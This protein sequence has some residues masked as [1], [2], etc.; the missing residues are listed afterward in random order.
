M[1]EEDGGRQVW[2][3][4]TYEWTRSKGCRGTATAGCLSVPADRQSVPADHLSIPAGRPGCAGHGDAG[5][6]EN[7]VHVAWRI[8]RDGAESL[9]EG[10]RSPGSLCRRSR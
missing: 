4:A 2:F 5:H 8:E 7:P 6:V 10:L 1:L 3:R 9:G